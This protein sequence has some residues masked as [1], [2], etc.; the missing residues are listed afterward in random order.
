MRAIYALIMSLLWM[1]TSRL[2]A[3][4]FGASM[5][6]T[7]SFEKGKWSERSKLSIDHRAVKKRS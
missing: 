7:R 4:P 2:R 5:I 3:L 6:K 1:P